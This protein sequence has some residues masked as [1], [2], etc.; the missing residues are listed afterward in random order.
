MYFSD[1]FV[2]APNLVESGMKYFLHATLKQCHEIKQNYYNSLFNLGLGCAFFLVLFV[3]L[4]L[5][6]K[7]KPTAIEKQLKEREKQQYILSKMKTFNESRQRMHQT[8]ITGLPSWENDY[9]NV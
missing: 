2:A 4:F 7:G 1:S 5:K 6:Y 3:F 8:L 9:V